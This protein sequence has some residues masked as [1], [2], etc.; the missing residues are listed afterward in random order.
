MKE[1]EN[2]PFCK[3]GSMALNKR[4]NSAKKDI[5]DHCTSD[6]GKTTLTEKLLLYGG[7]IQ[8]A[9]AV[10]ARKIKSRQPPIGWQW[11][12]ARISIYL[13]HALQFEYKDFV[14]NLLDTPGHET[15]QKTPALS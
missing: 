15:F 13:R 3:Y 14:L 2:Q 4:R 5:R 7:A 9:G 1:L 8:L 11:K 12:R 6:A 10:K